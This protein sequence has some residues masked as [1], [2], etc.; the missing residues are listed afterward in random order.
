MKLLIGLGNPGPQYEHTRH[1]VGFR[2]VDKLAAT[3]GWKWTE[4]R[5]RAI[6]ASGTI[7]TEKVVL[8]KPITF[9]N[10]SGEA[11]SELARWYKVQPEDMLVICD[12]L[13][14]PVG[15]MRLRTKGS[16]GGQNGLDNILHYLHTDMIPRLRVG[17]GRPTHTRMDPIDYV[18]GVPTSDERIL[19]EAGEDRAVEAIKMVVTQGFATTMNVVNADPEAEQRAAEKRQRQKERQEQ[20]R[21]RREAALQVQGEAEA[22]EINRS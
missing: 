21:L 20:A 7:G 22:E 4:R 1:N 12:D 15:R 11:V 8:V 17:I 6:L 14:L 18:L 16:A 2:V 13:D 9:M 19:L 3:L 5:S 10:R